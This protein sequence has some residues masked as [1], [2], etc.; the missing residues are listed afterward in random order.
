MKIDITG[1][2]L[3]AL[4]SLAQKFPSGKITASKGIAY[5]DFDG[6]AQVMQQPVQPMQYSPQAQPPQQP[7]K[8]NNFFNM[9]DEMAK[10]F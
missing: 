4:F 5:W 6:Q 8:K 7:E 10:R 2:D 1:S 3:Q 9:F